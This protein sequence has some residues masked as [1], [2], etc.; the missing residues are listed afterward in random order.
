MTS[1]GHERLW[2]FVESACIENKFWLKKCS[3]VA[4]VKEEILRKP[5]VNVGFGFCTLKNKSFT[6]LL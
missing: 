5:W 4:G 3:E 1:D 2:S 6:E